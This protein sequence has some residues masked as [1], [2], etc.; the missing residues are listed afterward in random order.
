MSRN[1][2]YDIRDIF[3]KMRDDIYEA[4]YRFIETKIR[5]HHTI[6]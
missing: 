3:I 1:I 5:V 2:S 4:R 6:E